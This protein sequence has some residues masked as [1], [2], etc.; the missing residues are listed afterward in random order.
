MWLHPV[1]NSSAPIQPSQSNPVNPTQLIQ[2][3]A[4][5]S[6]LDQ[7][8]KDINNNGTRPDMSHNFDEPNQSGHQR[9][10]PVTPFYCDMVEPAQLNSGWS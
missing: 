1:T 8:S 5:K 10:W 7:L 2:F 6:P 9:L 4:T 3:K